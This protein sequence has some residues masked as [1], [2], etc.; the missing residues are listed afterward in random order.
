M[1]PI[2][3]LLAQ[4]DQQSGVPVVRLRPSDGVRSILHDQ[5]ARSLDELGDERVC[6]GYGKG[7]VGIPLSPERG[8]VDASKVLAEVFMPRCDARE[9]VRGL[10]RPA[11]RPDQRLLTR[12]AVGH[13]GT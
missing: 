12:N 1:L 9:T 13:S 10:E 11:A 7:T 2:A 3:D 4:E 5:L 6:G 8:H